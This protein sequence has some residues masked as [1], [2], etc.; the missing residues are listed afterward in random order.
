MGCTSTY[1]Y[2]AKTTLNLLAELK[3][4][5]ISPQVIMGGRL[6][7][8]LEGEGMPIDVTDQLIELGIDVCFDLKDLAKLI[9]N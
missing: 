5:E 7:Q 1:L 3:K 9:Q 8:E 2:R 6:N 4:R